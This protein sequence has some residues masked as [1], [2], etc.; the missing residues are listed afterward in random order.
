VPNFP[1]ATSIVGGTLISRVTVLIFAEFYGLFC[2]LFS[3]NW[4]TEL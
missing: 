2:T 3:A 1:K 4:G